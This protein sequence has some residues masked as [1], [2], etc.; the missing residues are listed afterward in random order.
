MSNLGSLSSYLGIEIK[1]GKDFIFLSQTAYA[2][3]VLQHAKLGECNSA[4][5]PLEARAQLTYEEGKSTVNSTA[6]R[7]LIGSLRY[8]THARPDLLFAV[9]MLSRHMENP[10]QEHYI[11]VKRVL[12]YLKGTEDY[13]LF[14]KKGDLKGE[15]IGYSDSN[16]SGD[17]NDRKS[18]SGQIFFFGGMA[19]SW[20]S[21]KQSIV[22]LSSCE[23]EYIAATSATCQAVWMSRLIGELMS[24]EMT[25]VKLLVDNQSAITL[26]KNPVHRN[27]NEAH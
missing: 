6:Y 25:K 16:F 19:V 20:S 7:S 8:L 11:G 22:A 18:T 21:Q 17:C 4:F 5:T 27:P 10:T 26:S 9:G 15:L 13:G 2:Q 24:D 3:K 14:Y 12:R 1:Q 23:A